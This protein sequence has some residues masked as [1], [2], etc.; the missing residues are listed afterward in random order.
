MKKHLLCL[1]GLLMTLIISGCGW[2]NGSSAP[3]SINRVILG[4]I[5]GATV[6]VFQLT[7]LSNP[8]ETVTTSKG[9][10]FQTDGS[11]ALSLQGISDDELVLLVATGGEDLDANDDGVPDEIPT[12]NNGTI[13][14]LAPAREAR[15]GKVH[16]TAISEIAWQ[17]TNALVGNT[18]GE[19]IQSIRL[20]EVAALLFEGLSTQEATSLLWRFSPTDTSHR[21]ALKKRYEDL[22][23]AK[24]ESVIKAILS[25]KNQ[26]EIRQKVASYV[27]NPSF[28]M[29]PP[30][31][32]EYQSTLVTLDP[33]GKGEIKSSD[34][35]LYYSSK[36]SD[37]KNK[38]KAFYKKG[39]VV[40]L[41]ATPCD[42]ASFS[43]YEGV[44]EVDASTPL[45]ATLLVGSDPATIEASFGRKVSLRN[46]VFDINNCDVAL[47]EKQTLTIHT[48]PS[49]SE[50]IALL[51]SLRPGDFITRY[52]PPML[53]RKI[54]AIE[55]PENGTFYLD[56]EN[57]KLEEMVESGTFFLK[58]ALTSD[59]LSPSDPLE[60]TEAPSTRGFSTAFTPAPEMK[61]VRLLPPKHPGDTNFILD[62]GSK[63]PSSPT[64]RKEFNLIDETASFGVKFEA[65][66]YL[67]SVNITGQLGIKFDID[68]AL[69]LGDVLLGDSLVEEL[70]LVPTLTLTEAINL[71]I[72]GEAPIFKKKKKIGTINFGKV[73]LYPAPPVWIDLSADLF[74]VFD[75][76][77]SI[78]AEVGGSFTQTV[79]AGFHWTEKDGMNWIGDLSSKNN[80]IDTNISGSLRAEGYAQA[81]P[82]AYLFSVLGPITEIDLGY[83]ISNTLGFENTTPYYEF[84]LY[85]FARVQAKVSMRETDSIIIQS[86]RKKF[87]KLTRKMSIN[88]GCEDKVLS[89][90]ENLQGNSKVKIPPIFS[91]KVKDDTPLKHFVEQENI[92]SLENQ[93]PTFLVTNI[94]QEDVTVAA[95]L[96]SSLP[97]LKMGIGMR[98]VSQNVE[99][100]AS[101]SKTSLTLSPNEIQEVKVLLD[102]QKL[103]DMGIIGTN[104]LSI[105][106][107]NESFQWQPPV[108]QKIK[109]KVIEN[110]SAPKLEGVQI[111]GSVAPL[112]SVQGRWEGSTKLFKKY[113]KC[114]L[115]TASKDSGYWQNVYTFWNSDKLGGSNG[116][117]FNLKNLQLSTKILPSGKTDRWRI[118][119]INKINGTR[120]ISNEMDKSI[121]NRKLRGRII[122]P[123]DPKYYNIR[124]SLKQK[125]DGK[126]YYTTPREGGYFEFGMRKEGEKYSITIEEETVEITHGSGDVTLDP[127]A[128]IGDLSPAKTVITGTVINGRNKNKG[129][130]GVTLKIRKGFQTKDGAVLKTTTTDATGRYTF[131]EMEKGR[132]TIEVVKKETPTGYDVQD[133]PYPTRY[134]TVV[135][136]TWWDQAKKEQ[137]ILIFPE[138]PGDHSFYVALT[139]NESTD[140]DLHANATYRYT[141]HLYKDNLS[142]EGFF[143]DY[144]FFEEED[145]TKSGPEIIRFA[146]PEKTTVDLT[147]AVYHQNYK[148]HPLDHLRFPHAEAMVQL[149][150]KG[151]VQTFYPPSG[152]ENTWVPFR[153]RVRYDP[154]VP[155]MYLR[156][157]E[158]KELF[159]FQ[160]DYN[161][162]RLR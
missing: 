131:E 46:R 155:D 60:N 118:V 1:L 85:K 37:K 103:A 137:D 78:T 114:V 83:G 26:A 63:A 86:I 109:I 51:K 112:L 81:R 40:N 41:S 127:I 135:G 104:K 50:T 125:E 4:P 115:Q 3:S 25:G 71:D 24:D 2:E 56:T 91:L 35:K 106:F 29:S 138:M 10:G 141:T 12:A 22:L 53:S 124:I 110:L 140:L 82:G 87:E 95:T 150:W 160:D 75:G 136:N 49:D 88:I 43:G 92:I 148:S 55:E 123:A 102:A 154:D 107:S 149:F 59:D 38:L 23:P 79:K 18:S 17:Y 34:E 105:T 117:R 119:A 143:S 13:H 101:L 58:R 33:F 7:D 99:T 147:V 89:W 15:Q 151:E 68:A 128:I 31:G 111:K 73:L 30:K 8:V 94:G 21:D 28:A 67:A 70:K 76:N 62:F 116:Y 97:S 61:G 113:Y 134:V 39:S 126:V 145:K 142:L 42:D 5:A 54:I 48:D 32:D 69:E 132:Y 108:K 72:T 93:M 47:G 158:V 96:S 84:K 146:P 161:I 6:H 77:F 139:W 80:G 16:L 98:K 133:L 45:S 57:A 100:C 36:T 74:L 120:K 64:S 144:L 11:F 122:Y 19:E 153:L 130:P 121:N 90:R 44:T 9:T 14:A 20:K 66:D 162:W 152:R 159:N 27:G 156:L 65:D 129:Q 157:N 52:L